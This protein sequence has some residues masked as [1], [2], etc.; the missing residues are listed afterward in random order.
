M[1]F[2]AKSDLI[3]DQAIRLLQQGSIEGG[4]INWPGRPRPMVVYFVEDKLLEKK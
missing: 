3:T 2:E 4:G 1:M